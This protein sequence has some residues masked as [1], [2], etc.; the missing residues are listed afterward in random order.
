M[1]EP[2]VCTNIITNWLAAIAQHQA[3]KEADRRREMVLTFEPHSITFDDVTPACDIAISSLGW[4]TIEPVSRSLKISTKTCRDRWGIDFGRAHPQAYRD[5]CKAT[6]IDRQGWSRVVPIC[7]IN[8]ERRGNET[9]NVHTTSDFRILRD[10]LTRE[11][12]L[13]I[14]KGLPIVC[15]IMFAK[16]Y[17]GDA[18][19]MLK[20]QILTSYWCSLSLKGLFNLRTTKLYRIIQS[21]SF[22]T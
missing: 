12:L 15:Q 6:N 8:R 19:F 17:L 2:I 3:V 4:F 21:S 5:F 16:Y 11:V 1:R 18:S 7:R 14:P 9:K 10:A 22:I 20:R 13:I